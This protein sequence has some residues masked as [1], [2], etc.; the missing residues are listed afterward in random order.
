MPLDR[1][2]FEAALTTFHRYSRQNDAFVDALLDMGV[3][4]PAPNPDFAVLDLGAGQGHL[5]ALLRGRVGILAVLEP[6]AAC[7]AKLR[8]TFAPVYAAPWDEPACAGIARDYPHGFDLVSMSHMLYHFHGIDDIRAKVK[9]A[10]R[11]VKP[12][13]ALAIVVNQSDAPS[14]R[15]GM[16]FLCAND[17]M[18]EC[19]T[20]RQLHESCHDASFY[21]R[22]FGDEAA[23][24]V[25]ALDAPLA[26]V[27]NRDE[28]VAAL[29]MPLLDPL[30]GAPCDAGRLDRHIAAF[31]D[32]AYPG[33]AYPATL[34]SR[35]DMILIRRKAG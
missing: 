1:D 8:E 6:N 9:L 18:A 13:G 2:I 26:D 5:P 28:L 27:P 4:P 33:L 17:F 15:V 32:E 10:M 23:I 29:R 20:N 31:L 35:D 30:S 14:A 16:S 22:L 11:L 12:G 24:S 7:V 34:P 25:R 3:L 19:Q 21:A